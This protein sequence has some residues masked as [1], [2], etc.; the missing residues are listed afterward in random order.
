[1]NRRVYLDHN[2]STPVHPEVLEAMLPYFCERLRQSRRACT[3]SG[4]RR[5]T[6]VDDA[7]AS[8]IAH[9]LGVG[10]GRDR[11]HLRR[12]RIRQLRRSRGWPR[13]GAAGTSSPPRIEH[14][15]VLRTCAG[16]GEAGLRGDL[17][18]GGRAR[19]GGSG[20]RAAG[21]AARHHRGLDHARQLRGGDDPAGGRDRAPSRAS[22]AIPFH[23]D[24]VQ[25][26]GKLPIDVDAL[27]IDL[28]SFSGAQDLRAEG[29]GRA[30]H[31]QGHQDGVGAARRASTSGGVARA[32]RTCRASSASAGRWRS[33]GRDMAAEAE[34]LARAA[35]P[36][37]GRASSARVPEMP[38]QRPSDRAAARHLQHRA[39]ATSS[40][41]PSCSGLDLKGVAVSAG[42]GVHVGQRGA[43]RT[44]W[45]PWAC[46]WTGR[47]ARCGARW[48][49]PPPPRTST[50]WSEARS[51]W[52]G[53]LRSALA[54]SERHRGAY[55]PTLVDHFRNPRNAGMMRD[56]DGV[57]EDE[58]PDCMDLA[59]FYLRVRE[60]RVTGGAVPDLRVRADH[61]GGER[62]HRADDGARRGG[63]ARRRRRADRGGGG[64][65]ARGSA[66]TPPRWRRGAAGGGAGRDSTRR[67]GPGGGTACLS[68]CGAT[69]G[70][71]SSGIPRRAPS[72]R[73]CSAIPGV[74]AIWV[75]PAWP[76]GCGTRAGTARAA[77]SPHVGRF[78]TGHRDSS[79]PPGSG[80]ACSSTTA[81]AS[82]SARRP[83]WARTSALLQGVTLG[84]TSLKREKRHPTLGDNVVVGAG[85]KDARR[86]HHRRRAAGS[87]PARWWCGRCPANSVVVGVPGRVTYRD[88]QRVPG[89]I[90]LNQS[91]L[92]DPLA[93][94]RRAV[95]RAHAG[96]G[97]ARWRRL[98]QGGRGQAERPELRDE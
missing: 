20:R 84:G 26:F 51:R 11:V 69:C 22:T 34:R 93:R 71:C 54:R 76:T 89:E 47:W 4:A 14:H 80:P 95:D 72:S 75:P 50:T 91:D 12:H 28:L 85:A 30:L 61:R 7:R 8:A 58:Y 64:R 16:P 5:A 74:H 67:P 88:G 3:A 92:P 49:G 35:G 53:K 94:T 39:S 63:P 73:W 36:A 18:A 15:A 86:L 52:C 2:A 66:R 45:W 79:R 43:L 32:R 13:R 42:L 48:G 38:A 10:P 9:F 27:G 56:P 40:R 77:A 70:P 23:V 90:D 46:P 21:P 96:A 19:H 55:S 41:N 1:M 33:A 24:A 62:G 83:R 87:A 25:T 6:G 57:G 31:P 81:W 60:G 37:V 29:R 17:P 97:G 68:G 98:K 44:C 78:L 65:A 59:R 82:S